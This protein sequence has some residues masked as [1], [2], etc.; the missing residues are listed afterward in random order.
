[1][2]RLVT[3][4]NALFVIRRSGLRQGLE[5]F[6]ECFQLSRQGA[7]RILQPRKAPEDGAVRLGAQRKPQWSVHGPER[8]LRELDLNSAT[9]QHASVKIAEQR[10]DDPVL[11]GR[12][13]RVPLDVEK[14]GVARQLSFL[15]DVHPTPIERTLD[16]HVVRDEI[17]NHAHAVLLEQLA[18]LEQLVLPTQFGIDLVVIADVVAMLAAGRRAKNR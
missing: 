8:I 6:R 16:A 3:F 7:G 10:D 4:L 15:E 2:T 13:A 9:L 14:R 17:D 11:Q 5:L 18:E 1:M 12:L